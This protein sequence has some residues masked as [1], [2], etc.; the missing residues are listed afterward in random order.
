MHGRCILLHMTVGLLET[1]KHLTCLLLLPCAQGV[2]G[3]INFWLDVVDPQH[4][5][6]PGAEL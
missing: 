4:S 2:C 1:A 3:A 6:W 5:K